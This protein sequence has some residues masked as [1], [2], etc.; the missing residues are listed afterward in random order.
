MNPAD[1]YR[2]AHHQ[3]TG[4]G[5]QTEWWLHNRKSVTGIIVAHLRIGI[6]P[7]EHTLM[8]NSCALADAGNAGTM[9]RRGTRYDLNKDTP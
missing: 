7:Q 9:Q 4:V 6:T 3:L 2:Y 5:S 1:A 8:P